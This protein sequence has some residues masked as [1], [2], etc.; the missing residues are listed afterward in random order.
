MNPLPARCAGSQHKD[1]LPVCA[2]PDGLIG[3]ARDGEHMHAPARRI[4]QLGNSLEYRQE[5]EQ[6]YPLG[7]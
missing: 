4:G 5:E 3:R 2:D 6:R 1:P 7:V